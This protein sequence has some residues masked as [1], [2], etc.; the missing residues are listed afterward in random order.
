MIDQTEAKVFLQLPYNAM[1]SLC[2]NRERGWSVD[3]RFGKSEIG[4]RPRLGGPEGLKSVPHVHTHIIP[5]KLDDF[6]SIDDVYAKLEG[7][8][9]N[10]GDFMEMQRQRKIVEG[11]KKEMIVESLK[12]PPRSMEVMEAETQM[13][14]AEM[15]KPE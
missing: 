11:Q 6:P 8:E 14:A 12:R 4:Y 15:E 9:G 1:I 2:T 13:L 7:G 3:T 5:R 10:V